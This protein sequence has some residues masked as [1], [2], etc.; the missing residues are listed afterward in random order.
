N[1]KTMWMDQAGFDEKLYPIIEN[2]AMEVNGTIKSD[3]VA[4][5][6]GIWQAPWNTQITNQYYGNASAYSGKTVQITKRV[7]LSTGTVYY[8]FSQNG[9]NIGWLDAKAF[10]EPVLSSDSTSYRA[11]IRNDAVKQ[12]VWSAPYNTENDIKYYGNGGQFTGQTVSITKI[13]KTPRSTY[14]QFNLNGKTM[15]MD[16][17]GFDEK[18]YPIIEN[19][20]MEVNGTIK[21]DNVAKAQGIWQA[22]WNTQITNQYY[23]NASA[24]SGKTVQITKRVKLSTGTVYYQFSQNGKNIGWLDAKAFNEP[25]LSSDST[26]YRA[27]IRNDAVKQGVW[28]A[29]YN[30]END[31][32]YYGNGGQFTGQ[33]VSITKIVKTPRSTYLQFNLNGKTM[34]MDQAGFDEKLYPII[35]NEAME[36]NGTIKS[37]NVAKAQGIWQAPWN[38]QI[39]NQYYGNA[40]AY[41]GKTVQI[42]K[43]VKLSTGTVYYQFSQNGKNIGWLDAKAF[44]EPVLS[45]D[46][47]SYRA[48]IRNDAVKQGVWSAPYNTENDIKYYGNGGQFTGQTVSI[49]KIVKTPRS[50][51]LQFNLNGKTMWM[52]QA[53]F[54]EKLY[55][56]IENE[57][58]EVNGTIKSDNVVKAQGIWQA[59][60]NTQITNQYYGNAS[61]YSGKTVQITKRVKLSTGTVYYQFSQNGKN[62]GWLDAKAF[63]ELVL[64]EEN[65]QKKLVVNSIARKLD[66][67]SAP[68]NIHSGIKKIGSGEVFINQEVLV[69]KKVKTTQAVYLQF[70]FGENKYWM[71]ESAFVSTMSTK[72]KDK[73]VLDPP[74]TASYNSEPSNID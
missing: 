57:A 5:A 44:N 45:S 17:A 29:P 54:D 49:T 24:Y 31:I 16:Q 7:K 37:D 34:W 22:P 59:P 1:G 60:W 14:L 28:S 50:T 25:V 3:N 73:K 12:G 33:T 63:Y 69:L 19:E 72:T 47:T 6:Q 67:W 4:K 38:T 61:A 23:G 53:G 65:Y 46:S 36:V 42:T 8:Q 74:K 62:I 56:I 26:S 2:E 43:R 15:W 13:V 11:E 27:E 48:E 40:S 35:E 41:S 71:D 20:A 10:N 30:T 51:Y 64:K 66:V 58:M 68:Y 70:E 39:T 9:K 18:L 52:D 21:S 32:K 55:P